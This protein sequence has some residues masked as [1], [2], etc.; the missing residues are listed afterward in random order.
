MTEKIH[1]Y[2]NKLNLH[3]YV[4]VEIDLVM[5]DMYITLFT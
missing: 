2:F 1:K 4:Y 3:T 5:W